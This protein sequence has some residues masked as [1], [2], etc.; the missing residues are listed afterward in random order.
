MKSPSQIIADEV[1]AVKAATIL[2]ALRGKGW[3][4]VRKPLPQPSFSEDNWAAG[5]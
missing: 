4:V 1:G 2:A 3:E 5:F